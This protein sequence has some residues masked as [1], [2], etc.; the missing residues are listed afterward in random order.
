MLTRT[1]AM[2]LGLGVGGFPAG[3]AASPSAPRRRILLFTKSSGFEHSVIKRSGDRL[4]HAEQILTD[5]GAKH[6]FDVT[7]TKDGRVF[8]PDNIAKYD[9]FFFYTTGDLT[10]PGRDKNP[11]MSKEGKAAFW[12]RS[13]TARVLSA[14]TPPPT[15][16]TR[17]PTRRTG[18]TAT[19][20]RARRWILTSP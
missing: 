2:A 8:T 19:G 3:W 11:P 10:E 14:P 13:G 6:G 17:S 15:R 1:G 20:T 4:G 7:A 18:R 16:S 12:R 9:A 5:L